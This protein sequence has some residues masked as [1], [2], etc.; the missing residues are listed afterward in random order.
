MKS[1]AILFLKVKIIIE[2]FLFVWR[3]IQTFPPEPASA[4]ILAHQPCREIQFLPRDIV[5]TN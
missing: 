1:I 4:P 5:I 2:D 3:K